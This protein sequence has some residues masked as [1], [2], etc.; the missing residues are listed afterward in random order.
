MVLGLHG[1]LTSCILLHVYYAGT[2]NKPTHTNV[3]F[4]GKT[5][6]V[7][8]IIRA[9]E[10]RPVH[11]YVIMIQITG[12]S[13]QVSKPR[14][15][16]QAVGESRVEMVEINPTDVNCKLNATDAHCRHTLQEEAEVG[17]TYNITLCATNEFDTTCGEPVVTIATSAPVTAA[18]IDQMEST[19]RPLGT[20]LA[21]VISLLVVVLLCCLLLICVAFCSAGAALARRKGEKWLGLQVYV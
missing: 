18:P 20:I 12:S 5:I 1:Q 13:T 3:I 10:L 21:I 7:T 2:P 9:N 15:G 16:R 14:S 4:N 17:K 19:K 8:W 11:G 6:T